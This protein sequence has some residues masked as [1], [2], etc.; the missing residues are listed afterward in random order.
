M[1][2]IPAAAYI[3]TAIFQNRLSELS[4][5]E[6]SQS[7]LVLI[8]TILL[9]KNAKRSNTIKGPLYLAT[10][11]LTMI[12]IREADYYLDFVYHGFWKVPVF[13]TFCIGMYTVL[14]NKLPVFKPLSQAIQT[15]AFGY[16]M[17]GL[18]ITLIFSRLYG[19][20]TIWL[21]MLPYEDARYIKNIIQESLEL[22]GYCIVFLG[23]LTLHMA[24]A[25]QEKKH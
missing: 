25:S 5:T 7:S 13:I 23:T 4:M 6:L 9:H 1:L 2:Y 18:A 10:T 20:S 14:K 17:C 3:D 12:F 8:S 19:A 24:P 21:T 22:L 11:L 16:M 15:K